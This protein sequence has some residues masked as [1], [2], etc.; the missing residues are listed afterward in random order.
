M[1]TIFLLLFGHISSNVLA[2][3]NTLRNI[4]F[5][6][7]SK[8]QRPVLNYNE[9]VKLEYGIEIYGLNYFNQK[10]ERIQFNLQITE[11]WYDQYLVWN[12]SEYNY[13]FLDIETKRIWNPDIELYNSG[14]KPF[15][16]DNDN[17]RVKLHY[18]GHI[19]YNKFI[20]YSF[21]CMLELH[22]FPYDKQTCY[23]LFGSWKHSKAQL[24]MKP[25]NSSSIYKNISIYR[26]FSHNEWNIVNTYV[27]HK[28]LEY[29][30]CPGEL[31]PNT[32]FYI[33]LERDSMKYTIVILFTLFITF[34]GFAVSLIKITNYKRTF[35]LVFVPLSIIW[36]QIYISDKIPVIE[37]AT[38]MENLFILCFACT[39]ALSLES[40]LLYCIF[41]K[42][43]LLHNEN[44]DI[45][46]DNLENVKL[47][48]KDKTSVKIENTLLI[49]DVI[50]RVCVIT[51][52]FIV[53][54]AL[55]L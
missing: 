53:L 43:G 7:Y 13:E 31:Y 44:L 23:M 26:D 21:S 46:Y 28:D 51:V 35:V 15:S 14:I 2:N 52:F 29:L 49:F 38:F 18:D 10:A 47:I 37:Y 11:S 36:L 8:F 54:L 9:S 30:C 33:E 27:V 4:L 12:M 50:F 3:E 42:N 22:D 19:V 5:E 1:K 39:M 41:T 48:R 25:F 34:S 24:D 40:A 17:S 45:K 16:F 32:Y 20:T 55:F 6:N